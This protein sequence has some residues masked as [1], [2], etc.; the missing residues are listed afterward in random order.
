MNVTPDYA[1]GRGLTGHV[2]AAAFAVA[3]A[4]V[5]GLLAMLS[6]ALAV[7]IA[8]ALAVIGAAAVLGVGAIVGAAVVLLPWLVVLDAHIPALVRTA[9]SAGLCLSLLVYAS[10]LTFRQPVVTAGAAIFLAS[11]LIVLAQSADG[12]QVQQAA[13]YALFPLT[14]FAVSQTDASR[15]SRVTALIRPALASCAAALAVHVLLIAAGI[16]DIGTRYGAGERLGFAGAVSHELGL[17]AVLV[18]ASSLALVRDP[19]IQVLLLT[20]AGVTVVASGIRAAWV[21]L[22]IVVM[23]HLVRSKF[24]PRQ[25]LAVLLLALVIAVSGV[26]SV[27][28]ERFALGEQRGEYQSFSAAGSGRGSIWTVALEG[29]RDAG[30]AAWVTGTGLRSIQDFSQQK[31]GERFVGHSDILE[32][33]IQMGFIGLVGWLLIWIGL[34]RSGFDPYIT[35]A[36]L[37]FGIVNGAI[38]AVGPMML[39]LILASGGTLHRRT[40]GSSR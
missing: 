8:L 15:R 16:G 9:I 18:A 23:L 17:L 4:S 35:I 30:P 14:A 20:L 39:A 12:A 40:L 21:A 27:V 5:V 6:P 36:V 19:R 26:G 10:P 32:V 28:T 33:G 22:A 7:A 37:V 38:E 24:A 31:L 34:L 25:T 29:Y 1:H 2:A 13:K 3:I 11:L